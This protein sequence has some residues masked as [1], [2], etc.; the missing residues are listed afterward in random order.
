MTL[1]EFKGELPLSE[2]G[3]VLYRTCSNVPHYFR[4]PATSRVASMMMEIMEEEEA[5]AAPAAAAA[6]PAAAA[7]APGFLTMPPK[8]VF[9]RCNFK[10]SE[11]R[12]DLT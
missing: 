10:F 1:V 3:G 4:P 8:L 11:L 5:A 2:P 12:V 7:A 9:F 6:A